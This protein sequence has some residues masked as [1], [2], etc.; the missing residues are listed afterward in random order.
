VILSNSDTSCGVKEACKSIN[1]PPNIIIIL[2]LL[3]NELQE[4]TLCDNI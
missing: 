3:I 2:A 4:L 1:I